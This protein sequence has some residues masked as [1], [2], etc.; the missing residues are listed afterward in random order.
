MQDPAA[1]LTRRLLL[2]FNLSGSLCSAPRTHLAPQ[3]NLDNLSG[4][5]G[6]I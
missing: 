6:K 5:P 2:V 1:L 4:F 3:Q